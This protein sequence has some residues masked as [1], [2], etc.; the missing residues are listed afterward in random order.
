MKHLL[1]IAMIAA[2]SKSSSDSGATS[3]GSGS[4]KPSPTSKPNAQ[5][6]AGNPCERNLVTAADLAGILSEPI[7]GTKP[8][9]GDA[10]TCY[11]ITAS[12]DHGGPQIRV[13]VRDRL[14]KTTIASWKSGKMGT[15]ATP[16]AGVGDEALWVDAL[17]EVNATKNDTLCN[18]ALAGSAVIGHY[19]D[20]QTK[21]GAICNKIFAKL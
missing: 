11:F 7:T 16:L 18:V 1:V 9:Q 5:P 20:L 14:G 4:S 8:L 21:L 17:K 19:T 6:A 2:C 12:D 3:S 13:T 10:Q 15:D